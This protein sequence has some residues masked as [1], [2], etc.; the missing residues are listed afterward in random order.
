[1][2]TKHDVLRC[3]LHLLVHTALKMQ[4]LNK[5]ESHPNAS[6]RITELFIELL[7]RQHFLLIIHIQY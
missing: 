1:M 4:E 2:Q 5:Y 6:Q 3:Y 7:D